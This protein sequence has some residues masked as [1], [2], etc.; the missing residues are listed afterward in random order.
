MGARVL[1]TVTVVRGGC[2]MVHAYYTSQPHS[3]NYRNVQQTKYTRIQLAANVKYL[4]K[5]AT[6]TGLQRG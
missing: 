2:G 1:A 6:M 5:K 4:P 3:W